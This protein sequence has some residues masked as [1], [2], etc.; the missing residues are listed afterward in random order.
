VQFGEGGAGTFS[1]GKLWSQ[2]SDPRHL[3]RKV[4]TEFVQGRRAGGD[5]LRGKPHI[6]TFRLVSMI[7]KMRAEIE[8]W[9]AR[10]ASAAA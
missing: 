2:I 1:D 3:T 9:A 4:L 6:G 5:P 10:S 8:A 7:E